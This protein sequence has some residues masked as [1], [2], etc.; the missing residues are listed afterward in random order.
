M[1]GYAFGAVYLLVGAAGFLVTSG[2]G[3]AAT[4][5][6]NLIFFDV[7]PLHNIVHLAVGGLFVAGAVAGVRWARRVNLLVGAVYLLVGLVGLF[8]VGSE[9]NLIALN[10][11]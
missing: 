8:L 5:G 4:K 3:F 6:N 2:I 7:N 1:F 10:H 11:P 9:A